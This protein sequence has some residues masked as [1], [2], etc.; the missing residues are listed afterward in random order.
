M[1]TVPAKKRQTFGNVCRRRKK[2][3]LI[4]Q[5]FS[6]CP[7]S[8]SEWAVAT[9][10]LTRAPQQH[11]GTPPPAECSKSSP[12]NFRIYVGFKGSFWKVQVDT[13]LLRCGEVKQGCFPK[14]VSF[15]WERRA[16]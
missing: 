8:L 10:T 15:R 16:P 12:R 11:S 2:L 9:W 14:L 3:L 13:F 5:L 4:L 1:P 6:Q 7:K